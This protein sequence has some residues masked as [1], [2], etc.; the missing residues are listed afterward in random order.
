M[1]DKGQILGNKNSNYIFY[2]SELEDTPLKGHFRKMDAGIEIVEHI[3]KSIPGSKVMK[4]TEY[5]G[6]VIN[7]DS[8]GIVFPAHTWGISLA[9]LTFLSHLKI[10]RGTYIYAVAIG[11]SISGDVDYTIYDRVKLLDQFK[12]VFGKKSVGCQSDIFVRCIDRKR[13]HGSTEENLRGETDKIKTI[14]HVLSGLLFHTL[15]SI[16]AMEMIDEDD[17]FYEETQVTHSNI[18]PIE[19]YSQARSR[20]I[21]LSNIYLD[22]DIFRGVKICQVM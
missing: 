17:R 21:S 4:Y 16:S 20:K 15:D 6:E 3:K 8:I 9:V 13:T 14:K 7:A 18:I 12:K 1:G 2:V 22:E 10:R 11:E 5:S 19:A